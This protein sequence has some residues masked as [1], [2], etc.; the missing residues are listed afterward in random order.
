MKLR[1]PTTPL[2]TVD[3][4]FSVW[5]YD[6]INTKPP[7]HWTGSSNAMLGCVTIDGNDFLFLGDIR[8]CR[9]TKIIPQ[10]S[11][12]ISLFKTLVVF[13][14]ELIRL[15]AEFFTPSLITDLYLCSRPV[16]FCNVYWE[17]V[18]GK[19]HDVSVKVSVSEELVLNKAG[20][21]KTCSE[22]VDCG[23]L[24]VMKMGN[25]RQDI[26]WRSGDDVRI[27]WGYLYLAADTT[28][29]LLGSESIGNKEFIYI[30]TPLND[31]MLFAFAYDDIDS[32][33]YFG[34][35]LKAYWK[36]DGKTIT[37]AI[38]D[39]IRE[40]DSLCTRCADF[41]SEVINEAIDKGGEEYSELL[42]LAYRQ[43]MA[44]HKLVI[45]KEGNNLFISKECFSNGC[46]A[47]VDVTYPSAP[48]FLKYNTELLKGMLRPIFRYAESKDWIYDFAPHDAGQFPILN[49]QAYCSN[50][51]EEQMPVEECGNMLILCSAVCRVDNNFDFIKPHIKTLGK[52]SKYLIKYGADPDDQLCT[53][54]FAGRL[55]H[56]CNLSIKAIMGI[57]GYS[58]ILKNTGDTET[59][60]RLSVIAHE[61]A[62]SFS[63][64]A[65]NEDGS[66]RLAYDKP[67]TFSLK[68]NAVW[69]KIWGTKLFPDSFFGNEISRY[70]K[71]ANTYGV[72]LDN[73]NKYSKSDWT[74]WA[75]CLSDSKEDFSKIVHLLWQS[76]NT[77]KGRVPM[78]DWYYTDNADQAGYAC[79]FQHRSVQGGL[80]MRL[81]SD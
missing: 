66:T 57:A 24:T 35:V 8:D 63:E 32:I 28:D 80:F 23:D 19:A 62:N 13:E 2:I 20:E 43:V 49:G 59:S 48:L 78:T 40:Y 61:Y 77:T 76:Y 12:D 41:E 50:R 51:K 73:R 4:Y 53:D 33:E 14:N 29:A 18:D 46:A 70:I 71:E 31:R 22:A 7:F 60:E 5:S 37:D 81:L 47:T 72:P 1:A 68:Y 44:A 75:A 16:S 74:L 27:D 69:D 39:A 10:V 79:H 36:K 45:D 25:V 11:C 17:S 55:A 34:D 56:N 65:R 42:T 54:D 3:P 67:E 52:W 30:K 58:Y 26:L 9:N 38:H 6:D 15:T 21:G 64:R